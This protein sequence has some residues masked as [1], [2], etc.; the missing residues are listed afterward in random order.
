MKKYLQ[1]YIKVFLYFS[2]GMGLALSVIPLFLTGNFLGISP[3][4]WKASLMGGMA[5]SLIIVTIH[6]LRLQNL[7]TS[8]RANLSPNQSRTLILNAEASRV[9]ELCNSSVWTINAKIIS[10]NNK[11][12]GFLKAKTPLTF[13]SWG[14]I[15]EI[16][17]SA[18]DEK[19]SQVLVTS[20]PSVKT[21]LVDYGKNTEN[22]EKICWYLKNKLSA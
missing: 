12:A 21:T 6:V 16:K 22:V 19:T 15:I 20:S 7:P 11:N 10:E 14:E 5:F 13:W 4:I 17:V 9:F 2:V 3:F 18:I 1:L 8:D